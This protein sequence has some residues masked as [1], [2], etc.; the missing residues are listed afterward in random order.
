MA[1]PRGTDAAPGRPRRVARL[2]RGGEPAGRRPGRRP[3]TAQ[4]RAGRTGRRCPGRACDG[5]PLPL[6]LVRRELTVGSGWEAC[7]SPLPHRPARRGPG[8]NPAPPAVKAQRHGRGRGL[9]LR[10]PAQ[11]ARSVLLH[12]LVLLGV[13]WGNPATPAALRARS[14]RPGH[15]HWQPELAVAVVEAGRYGTTV[16]AAAAACVAE[17]AAGVRQPRGP[18]RTARKLPAR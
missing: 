1:G 18:Q 4:P 15:S 5:S 16:A 17:R 13:H 12:R 3:G 2:R 8:R 11:L 14:R 7:R 9:D 6:A 10:K